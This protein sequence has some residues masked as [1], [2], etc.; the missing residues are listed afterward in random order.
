MQDITI[1]NFRKFEKNTFK[2]NK[3][4][5]VLI[6]KNAAGKTTILE[7]VNVM[8]GA[9]LAAYKEY[10]PSR[11]VIN[12]SERDV[13]LKSNRNAMENAVL[14][15][16]IPQYPCTISCQLIWDKKSTVCQDN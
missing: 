6:G 9:Y 5:N 4:M 13:L 3:S 14:S 10:V 16:E 15:P 7:A 12:I 8:P 11:F 2:L 1:S